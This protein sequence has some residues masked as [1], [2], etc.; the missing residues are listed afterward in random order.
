MA[1]THALLAGCPL[2]SYDSAQRKV[3]VTGDGVRVAL[4][5]AV[6]SMLRNL[7][8]DVLRVRSMAWDVTQHGM[9]R[10][11][12]AGPLPPTRLSCRS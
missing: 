7:E 6:H 11:A 9:G 2:N 8:A 5:H 1:T 10:G 3:G 4:E 12:C